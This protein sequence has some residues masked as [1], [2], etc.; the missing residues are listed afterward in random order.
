M[1]HCARLQVAV[2]RGGAEVG[3]IEKVMIE[4]RFKRVKR[5]SLAVIWGKSVSGRGNGQCQGP[6]VGVCHI[7]WYAQGVARRLGGCAGGSEGRRV[8]DGSDPIGPCGLL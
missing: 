4:Q 5:E 3:L 2:L 6:E 1:S 7:S 8:G